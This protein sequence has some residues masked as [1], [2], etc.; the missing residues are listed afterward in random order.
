MHSWYFLPVQKQG[1]AS[2][3]VLRYNPC[4]AV[5]DRELWSHQDRQQ[6]CGVGM[7]DTLIQK[8]KKTQKSLTLSAA[9][10]LNVSSGAFGC[11]VFDYPAT[12]TPPTSLFWWFSQ[13][14]LSIHANTSLAH[15]SPHKSEVATDLGNGKQEKRSLLA[16][17]VSQMAASVI[18]AV[19]RVLEHACIPV[20]RALVLE[21]YKS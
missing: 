5:S 21:L 15:A 4:P 18:R 8:K 10:D 7:K 19:Q 11:P 20:S 9:Q 16:A 17:S 6:L 3:S 13:P 12:S 14:A 1:R 2:K